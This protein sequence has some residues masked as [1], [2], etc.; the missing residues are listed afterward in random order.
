MRAQLGGTGGRELIGREGGRSNCEP[1]H[2][3]SLGRSRDG[4][5]RKEEMFE[6]S[7]A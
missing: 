3:L 6:Y 7:A 4:E 2:E 1:E 5:R